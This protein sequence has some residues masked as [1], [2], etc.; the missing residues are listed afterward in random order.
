[1]RQGDHE[2]EASVGYRAR[3]YMPQKTKTKTKKKK[4]KKKKAFSKRQCLPLVK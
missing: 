4:K 3:T 1:L 2:F